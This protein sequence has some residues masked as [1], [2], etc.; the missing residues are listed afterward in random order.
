MFETKVIHSVQNNTRREIISYE[1]CSLQ[2]NG[3]RERHMVATVIFLTIV[4]K[5]YVNL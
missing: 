5:E 2:L 1:M 3:A 4:I